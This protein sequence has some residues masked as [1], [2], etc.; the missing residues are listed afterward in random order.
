MLGWGMIPLGALTLIALLSAL[1]AG[2]RRCGQ[3]SRH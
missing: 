2:A 1:L 3:R